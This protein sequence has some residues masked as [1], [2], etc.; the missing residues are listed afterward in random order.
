MICR[1]DWRAELP[2]LPSLRFEVGKDS[3]LI[4]RWFPSLPNL[5][6]LFFARAPTRVREI[7]K[8]LGRLGRLGRGRQDKAFR[9]P[10]SKQRLGRL[11]R[12][13]AQWKEVS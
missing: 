8:T 5:P 9:L 2:S 3:P 1:F 11:G 13:P 4:F 10:T 7:E 6:S 12:F